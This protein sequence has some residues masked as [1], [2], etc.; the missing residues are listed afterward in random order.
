MKKLWA[1]FAL[2]AALVTTVSGCTIVDE[3]PPTP[4]S[5]P[6][7]TAPPLVTDYPTAT[8]TVDTKLV[9][10]VLQ[11]NSLGVSTRVLNCVGPQ[12]V[13][14]TNIADADTA[15]ALIAGS[16]NL[17][18]KEPVPSDNKKCT[19]TGDQVVADVFGESKGKHVRVSFQRNNLCN[20]KVWDTV[21]PLIGLD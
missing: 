18:S 19:D 13:V 7:A 9:I 8:G 4:M 16:E 10:T 6:E 1:A 21:S 3:P 5:P 12:A 11:G 20:A 2:A 14:P 17:F 15:C